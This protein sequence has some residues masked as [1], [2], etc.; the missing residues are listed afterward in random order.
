MIKAKLAI[1][2]INVTS[3]AREDQPRLQAE[4]RGTPPAVSVY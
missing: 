2:I 4:K 3:S 1:I